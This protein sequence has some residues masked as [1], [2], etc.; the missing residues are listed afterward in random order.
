[1]GSIGDSGDL[2]QHVATVTPTGDGTYVGRV[3]EYHENG[4][5]GASYP[6]ELARNGLGP[7]CLNWVSDTPDVQR[8]DDLTEFS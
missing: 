7:W 8:A 5:E 2:K 6:I 4:S 3:V 1:M